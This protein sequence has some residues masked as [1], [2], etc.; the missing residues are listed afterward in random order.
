MSIVLVTGGFDPIHSGH[1]S[2]FEYAAKLGT[3]LVV[4]L[5]SDDWLARKKGQPFMPYEERATI[6]KNLRM[7]DHVISF[8]DDNGTACDAIDKLLLLYPDEKILFANG[9]DRT[10]NSTPEY[11]KF[12][13]H[14]RVKFYFGV[15]GEN[16]A[17]SSSWILDN[18]KT[19]KTIRPWGYWRVLDD[20]GIVKVKELVINPGASLTNQRHKLRSEHWYI[21]KGSC[22]IITE[23]YGLKNKVVLKPNDNYIIEKDVWHLTSNCNDEPCYV[24]EIQYGEKCSELDIERRTDD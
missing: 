9:G 2:Y 8:N 6:V 10:T 20:K 17:N 22:Q 11:F 5:N 14:P 19:Q 15:G 23:W 24:L 13:D 12:K 3:M 7:V 16:K 1:I 21:L 4:G 18:W